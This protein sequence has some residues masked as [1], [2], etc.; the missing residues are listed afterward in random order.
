MSFELI[1]RGD[2]WTLAT[3]HHSQILGTVWLAY[4]KTE[5]IPQ[6]KEFVF[7]FTGR[8]VGAIGEFIRVKNHRIYAEDVEKAKLL[9]YKTHEHIS[10]LEVQAEEPA[11]V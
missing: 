9:I 11:T 2:G 10:K 4:I 5:T 6:L 3:T 1:N 7:N 8:K